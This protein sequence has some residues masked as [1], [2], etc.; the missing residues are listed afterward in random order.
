MKNLTVQVEDEDHR[1]FFEYC[2]KARNFYEEFAVRHIDYSPRSFSWDKTKKE[3]INY[4]Y[5]GD[6]S[7]SIYKF[8]KNEILNNRMFENYGQYVINNN[9]DSPV[10]AL[11]IVHIRDNNNI[12]SKFLV[13]G[14]ESG[15]IE[16]YDEK[17]LESPPLESTKILGSIEI[18]YQS[19]PEGTI[20]TSCSSGG[21]FI[22]NINCKEN[23][24]YYIDCLK[25]SSNEH[26]SSI[27]E[28]KNN[29]YWFG[30]IFGEIFSIKHDDDSNF[31]K[32]FKKQKEYCYKSQDPI[33]KL[34]DITPNEKRDSDNKTV[35]CV[36]GKRVMC[37]RMGK[38]D[39]SEDNSSWYYKSSELSLSNQ[40]FD[41][42]VDKFECFENRTYAVV[43]TIDY[44]LYWIELKP[45]SEKIEN[46]FTERCYAEQMEMGARKILL[47]PL[48]KGSETENNEIGAYLAIAGGDQRVS[49]H[50]IK[51]ENQELQRI[52][53]FI[54]NR[55]NITSELIPKGEEI[56]LITFLTSFAR[57]FHGRGKAERRVQDTIIHLLTSYI[58]S[59]EISLNSKK[60]CIE[61][62]CCIAW[63]LSCGDLN[64]SNRL[65]KR[66]N[67]LS[68]YV[69]RKNNSNRT[70]KLIGSKGR[71][72]ISELIGDIKKY[73][74]EGKSFS[75]K[76]VRLVEL[77][78]HNMKVG[79]AFDADIYLATLHQRKY[80]LL[81]EKDIRL[82]PGKTTVQSQ[83]FKRIDDSSKKEVPIFVYG[84]SE[85]N[86]YF[87]N[88]DGNFVTG[89]IVSKPL[90]NDNKCY[91]FL[92]NT[93]KIVNKNYNSIFITS[94]LRIGK[95]V[96]F[97]A[98]DDGIIIE[99]PYKSILNN[100]NKIKDKSGYSSRTNDKVIV[101]NSE[102]K[103]FNFLIPWQENGN[104][105]IAGL[106]SGEVVLCDNNYQKSNY[107]WIPKKDIQKHGS[108]YSITAMSCAVLSDKKNILAVGMKN[109]LVYLFIFDDIYKFDQNPIR[110]EYDTKGI[111]EIFISKGGRKLIVSSEG[112]YSHI[113]SLKYYKDTD[114]HDKVENNKISTNLEKIVISAIKTG[115]PISSIKQVESIY[116]E[117]YIDT[118]FISSTSSGKYY[119]IN[120]KCEFTAQFNIHKPVLKSDLYQDIP[121][122]FQ[123]SY[124][125]KNFYLLNQKQ[126]DNNYEKNR[127]IA[128]SN[129]GYVYCFRILNT[130]IIEKEFSPNLEKVRIIKK[131]KEYLSAISIGA[132]FRERRI[133]RWYIR[134]LRENK[135]IKTIITKIN[136]LLDRGEYE[137]DTPI[138]LG[139]LDNLFEIF[140]RR[141][142]ST[143]RKQ[144]RKEK[145]VSINQ[146]IW[147]IL[148][149]WGQPQSDVRE[150]VHMQVIKNIFGLPI[151]TIGKI[152]IK[153]YK[154]GINFDIAELLR[155]F[156]N[157][158]KEKI[159]VSA[160]KRLS[161]SIMKNEEKDI[162][163]IDGFEKLLEAIIEPLRDSGLTK[164]YPNW[165]RFETLQ[166][167]AVMVLN[168]RLCP[169]YTA[170]LIRTA[171]RVDQ[172]MVT[173]FAT[174]LKYK[175]S[176]IL[177][178]N[179]KN[180]LYEKA[181]FTI[182][183]A[184][185]IL[186]LNQEL[187]SKKMS[188]TMICQFIDIC[189]SDIAK[190]NCNSNCSA[191]KFQGPF[192]KIFK[193]FETCLEIKTV[194]EIA[195][196]DN[197]F[198]EI[199]NTN[200]E[201]FPECR[202]I[203]NL[204]LEYQKKISEYWEKE[205][206]T[207]EE[208]IITKP[209]L[210]N[211]RCQIKHLSEYIEKTG[212][213]I[214]YLEKTILSTITNEWENNLTD[215]CRGYEL[216]GFVEEI[217]A[218]TKKFQNQL[219]KNPKTLPPINIRTAYKDLFYRFCLRLMPDFA[220]C[221]CPEFNNEKYSWEVWLK[222]EPKNKSKIITNRSGNNLDWNVNGKDEK[223]SAICKRII[224]DPLQD[225][226]SGFISENLN[227]FE[228]FVTKKWFGFQSNNCFLIVNGKKGNI[229][230][231]FLFMW[232]GERQIELKR[233][234]RVLLE[235]LPDFLITTNNLYLS[236]RETKSAFIN[237]F[238][239]ASHQIESP[240]ASLLYRINILSK[241]YL[242]EKPDEI[243]KNILF[244]ESLVDD[245]LTNVRNILDAQEL[246]TKGKNIA[247][248]SL[249]NVEKFEIFE[250]LNQIVKIVRDQIRNTPVEL[251]FNRKSNYNRTEGT[252][253]ETD[254][255]KLKDII[256]NLL[257]NGCKYSRFADQPKVDLNV[258]YDHYLKQIR[259]TIEDNGI[260]IPL[261]E[262]PQIF[263]PFFRG[264]IPESQNI[265]GSG[266]GLFVANAWI[267]RLNGELTIQNIKEKGKHG[268][269]GTVI[270]RNYET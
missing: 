195:L 35:L 221:V 208:F 9:K 122:I 148:K 210:G 123:K 167:L 100:F 86:I 125:M 2:N 213:D 183:A 237:S 127:I 143:I 32:E 120:N 83:F 95:N 97:V 172:N 223:L 231:G 192:R 103:Y 235:I 222:S 41:I 244:I 214:G 233:A 60:A 238:R 139:H 146:T 253:I 133:S 105:F 74:Y 132:D 68:K 20:F 199:D 63:L 78:K 197:I 23:E 178:N 269:I 15:R 161:V 75:E 45:N 193:I 154:I 225:E 111:S 159:R 11:E 121:L 96:L 216:I 55:L 79:K 236:M 250:F 196:S 166:L 176:T 27:C 226:I 57:R 99:I 158:P 18:I 126:K 248:R 53:I 56:K 59:K 24:N 207:P 80:D 165:V 181:E 140:N 155:H 119:S 61:F 22:L 267:N 150:R 114:T 4:F 270:I 76:R 242:D 69:I 135:N 12:V 220:M 130:N 136:R 186:K 157:F 224:D 247:R 36:T 39:S 81:W 245:C 254:R 174:I 255:I 177:N 218:Y 7:G 107:L 144:I 51:N 104:S 227:D 112:S 82:S 240:L 13:A 209:L 89:N 31:K 261:D 17:G 70:K 106:K 54:K 262:E 128:A 249:V 219:S 98:N 71:S 145:I 147:R 217:P 268:V 91:L 134:S 77:V 265:D 72:T 101:K 116:N 93:Q 171:S 230:S 234:D 50:K 40:L 200:W 67:Y 131:D 149:S 48:K 25:I 175:S 215:R 168:M 211:L 94:L 66:L 203:L 184:E 256:I 38:D 162:A 190:N 47:F 5:V 14:F 189:E 85:K 205:K 10:T 163:E 73:F 185:S 266:L 204:L 117:K 1:K 124:T 6:K 43:S 229:R 21:L 84:T 187:E 42:Y 49:F 16:L 19:S 87:F 182:K 194:Q 156:L 138:L 141:H 102:A 169:L 164:D 110:F 191:P 246:M 52:K 188:S 92:Y 108:D 180:K 259:I 129:D 152:F 151:N 212:K 26:I 109:G 170:Y 239:Y 153:K 232:D 258:Y 64:I 179:Y 37:I 160:L 46:I 88:K 137:F 58:L 65:V 34:I 264:F 44:N 29:W 33:D 173:I 257:S 62:K 115:V 8:N 206:T 201:Y 251:Q 263:N 3:N 228:K 252:T 113:Y 243:K 260:G 118:K 202:N 28:V 198:N 241:G 90:K 30:T 142:T